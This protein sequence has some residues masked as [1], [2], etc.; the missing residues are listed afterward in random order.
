MEITKSIAATAKGATTV[1]PASTPTGSFA[2]AL[3]TQSQTVTA[4]SKTIK[5]A[6]VMRP[7]MV[8]KAMSL[9]Q[10]SRTAATPAPMTAAQTRATYGE[11]TLATILARIRRV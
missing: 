4:R 9:K 2:K 11:G 7:I 1:T 5:T 8:P 3:A 10:A 6:R